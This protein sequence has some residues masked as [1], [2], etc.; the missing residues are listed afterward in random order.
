MENDKANELDTF[1]TLHAG[2]QRTI[3]DLTSMLRAAEKAR[4]I[5][6]ADVAMYEQSL[7]EVGASFSI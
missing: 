1:R 6:V 3:T 2:D 4:A 5:A 7:A